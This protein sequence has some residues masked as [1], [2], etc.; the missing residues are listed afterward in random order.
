M[1]FVPNRPSCPARVDLHWAFPERMPIP[2]PQHWYQQEQCRHWITPR[3]ID[4]EKQKA[5]RNKNQQMERN[6]QTKSNYEMKNI[7][8]N[9]NHNTVAG[10][11]IQNKP[12]QAW[13]TDEWRLLVATVIW[14]QQ[15]LRLQQP[16]VPCVEWDTNKR[17][18]MPVLHRFPCTK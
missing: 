1:S 18:P 3:T 17:L 5:N 4:S 8:Y 11:P 12:K 6:K 7:R 14:R 16:D 13:F 15:T 9:D 10:N 2:D